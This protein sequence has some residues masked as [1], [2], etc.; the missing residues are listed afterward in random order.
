MGA[1][2]DAALYDDEGANTVDHIEREVISLVGQRSGFADVTA[3]MARH[4]ELR[5]PRHGAP[6]RCDAHKDDSLRLLI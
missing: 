2:P 5:P 6:F 4:L 1:T 3:T